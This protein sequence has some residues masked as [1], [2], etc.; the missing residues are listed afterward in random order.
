MGLEL[1]T[2]PVSSAQPSSV[3]VAGVVEG[4]PAEKAGVL[5]GDLLTAVDGEEVRQ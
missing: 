5:P 4:S 3:M 2:A 1:A